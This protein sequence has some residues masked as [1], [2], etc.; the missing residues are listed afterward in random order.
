M[1]SFGV[2]AESRRYNLSD[3]QRYIGQKVGRS[4]SSIRQTDVPQLLDRLCDFF[5]L[6]P[7]GIIG[8]SARF[9]SAIGSRNEQHLGIRLHTL[10]LDVALDSSDYNASPLTIVARIEALR[11]VTR[12]IWLFDPMIGYSHRC[13]Q[14]SDDGRLSILAPD[15]PRRYSLDDPHGYGVFRVTYQVEPAWTPGEQYDVRFTHWYHREGAARG[16]FEELHRSV[17]IAWDTIAELTLSATTPTDR[18]YAPQWYACDYDEPPP[19]PEECQAM[20]MVLEGEGQRAFAVTI[21]GVAV[22]GQCGIRIVDPIEYPIWL[23]KLST[24]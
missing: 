17:A 20:P 4:A 16:P 12:F 24:S 5:E 6:S 18:A 10:S 23:D 19:I 15:N 9:S 14:C 21:G 8:P 2:P 1:W 13:T 7:P 11:S 22:G 3:R